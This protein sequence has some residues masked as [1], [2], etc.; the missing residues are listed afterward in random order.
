MEAL[1]ADRRIGARDASRDPVCGMAVAAP[2]IATSF[3]GREYLS[4]LEACRVQFLEAPR[5][6]AG[7]DDG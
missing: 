4:C 6:Y 3:D 1:A 2:V 5:R 7:R